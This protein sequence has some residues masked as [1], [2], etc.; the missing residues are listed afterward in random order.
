M[1]RELIV[2]I[3]AWGVTIGIVLLILFVTKSSHSFSRAVFLTWFTLAPMSVFVVHL[4][5]R[6]FLRSLRKRGLDLKTAVIV[7]AGEL[8]A[9][10]ASYMDQVPWAG[11]KLL[12]FF[13][14]LKNKEELIIKNKYV[15]GDISQLPEYVR[16]H[17]VDYIYIAL[18]MRAEQKIF[19]LIFKAFLSTNMQI[20]FFDRNFK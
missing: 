15:L 3:K 19:C 11:I 6:Y 7:G 14:D 10:F 5:C 1:Y 9:K 12:G 18:P 16:N 4:V 8:G 13:D 2:I 17:K 20:R